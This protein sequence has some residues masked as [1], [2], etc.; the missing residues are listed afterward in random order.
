MVNILYLKQRES[1]F[2]LFDDKSSLKKNKN[3]RPTG[4]RTFYVNKRV[5]RYK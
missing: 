4:K 1:Y 3:E 5:K 2:Y